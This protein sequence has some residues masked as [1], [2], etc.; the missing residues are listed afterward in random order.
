MRKE[1]REAAFRYLF[2]EL[3]R[4][5][6]DG[7]LKERLYKTAKLN[8][9]DRAFSDRLV[10][11]VEENRGALDALLQERVSSV[12][13]YRMYP[14]DRAILLLALAEI[15]YCEEIPPRVSASE[16]MA[17]ADKYSTESSATF[18]NGVLGGVMQS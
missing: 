1:A 15:R 5:E 6:K 2:A 12:Q 4:E 16:A 9:E 10:S 13:Q 3:F 18:I 7:R 17:L 14:A 8:E 11:L